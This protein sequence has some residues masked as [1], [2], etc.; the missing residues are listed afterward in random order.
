MTGEKQKPISVTG[1]AKKA[2]K[3][4]AAESAAGLGDTPDTAG[5]V[6][7]ALRKS[8][9]AVSQ[10]YDAALAPSGLRATQFSL[11]A[12]LRAGGRLTV[13]RLAE[14][15]VMDRTTLSRNLAPV[16]KQGLV[17]IAP[18]RRDG[19]TKE[20]TLT[21]RGRRRLSRA[22]P[23]W[24]DAQAHMRRALGVKRSDRLVFELDI[25]SAAALGR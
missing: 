18:G 9:R 2:A 16:E 10:L 20:I 14:A 11:L 3:G 17:K 12:S 15:M 19:R 25:A 23:L 1:A 4:A 13:S 24:A 5:C 8:A 22:D 7:F 6:C 21:A